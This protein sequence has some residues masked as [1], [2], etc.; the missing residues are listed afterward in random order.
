MGR[1]VNSLRKING[2]IGDSAKLLVGKWK[3]MVMEESDEQNNSSK[4]HLF[5]AHFEKLPS[6]TVQSHCFYYFIF[7]NSI[8][9]CR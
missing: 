5:L 3:E 1:T 6:T 9:L 4:T 2:K 7:L 8:D